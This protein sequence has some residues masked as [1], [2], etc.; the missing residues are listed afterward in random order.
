MRLLFVHQNFPGQ[1]RNIV[2][3]L[4]GQPGIEIAAI[5]TKEH[6][7]AGLRYFRYAVPPSPAL[8]DMALDDTVAKM[9]RAAAVAAQARIM[10][11]SGYEPDVIVAHAGWGEALYLADIFPRARLVCYCEYHYLR[12]GGDIGFDPEFPLRSTE[13]LHRLRTRNALERAVL[14]EAAACVAPTEWQRSTYPPLIRSRIEVI[15]DGIDLERLRPGPG[16]PVVTATG[17]VGADPGQ[18]VLTYVA[19]HLEPHRG[20]HVLLRL[21]PELLALEPELQ[22]LIVG[23]EQGGYGA[24]TEGARSWK[25]KLWPQAARELDQRRVHF[26]GWLGY[27]DY[28]NVLRL[29]HAHLY[30]SYPFVLSWS[31]LEALALECAVVASRT[32]PVTE[33]MTDGANARLADFFDVTSLVAAIRSLL[34]ATE[35][36]S[37][38]KFNARQTVQQRGLSIDATNERWTRLLKSLH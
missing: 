25:E 5:G 38:L 28:V 7:A 9:R 2:A 21:L 19:R 33:F 26:L 34:P 36:R 11:M 13:I 17:P 31:A 8:R 30:M 10:R 22:V 16:R 35:Q 18:P 12:E 4:T 3:H 24:P 15:H 6:S 23:S 32:P 1:F 37:R 27:Q 20:F 29:S 14:D